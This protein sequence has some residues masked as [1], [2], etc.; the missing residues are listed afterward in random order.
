MIKQIAAACMLLGLITC[1]GCAA[2][3]AGAGAGVYTYVAGEL[4]RTYQAPFDK[5]VTASLEALQSLKMIVVK[6]E[7][8]GIT[9]TITAK[10]SDE[11]PVTTTVTIVGPDMTEVSVRTGVFGYWDKKVSELVQAH[12]ANRL[13]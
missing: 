12:I 1:S 8:S 4:K 11:T 13:L 9:T 7:S 3:V 6:K 2:L 10:K 5:T